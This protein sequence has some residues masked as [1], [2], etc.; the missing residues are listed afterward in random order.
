M[1]RPG[2]IV[3]LSGFFAIGIHRAAG[4]CRRRCRAVPVGRG[5]LAGRR[6]TSIH[7]AD[8]RTPCSERLPRPEE[9]KPDAYQRNITARAFDVARYVLFF[10]IPTGVGQVTSIR[11]LERQIRRLKASE[12]AELREIAGEMA[13]ACAAPP[14]VRVGRC[15]VVRAGGAHARAARRSRRARRA[16]PS[17]SR[18][19]GA[20]ESTR[21]VEC[22]I[23]GAG[24]RGPRRSTRTPTLPRRCC[25][26]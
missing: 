17:R 19:V 7:R 20:P 16:V 14:A 12:Y 2:A 6:I 11:T 4:A 22:R 21:R 24:D 5:A 26:R 25:S 23:H 3:A 13:E 15:F 8:D 18:V 1:G 10:G 9:M